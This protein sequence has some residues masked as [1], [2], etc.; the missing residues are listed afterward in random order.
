MG[1]AIAREDGRKRPRGST[2]PTVYYGLRRLAHSQ[3]G[4]QMAPEEVH[5]RVLLRPDLSENDVI[6]A[7]L[8]I[9]IDTAVDF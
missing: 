5:K 2:H 3:R 7:G 1:F 8:H 4:R 9:A 6:V